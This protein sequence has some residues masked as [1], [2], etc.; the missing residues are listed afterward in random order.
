MSR[1][2]LQLPVVGIRYHEPAYRAAQVRVGDLLQLTWDVHNQHDPWAIAVMKGRHTIGYIPRERTWLLHRYRQLR[3]RLRC[4]QEACDEHTCH[5]DIA[6]AG[7]P[8]EE[9]LDFQ[10]FSDPRPTK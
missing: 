8:K 5:I 1:P 3:V 10:C 7:E 9:P 4:R 2:I 6:T